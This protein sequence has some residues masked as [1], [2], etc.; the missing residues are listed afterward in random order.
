M[1]HR[2]TQWLASL[3]ADAMTNAEFRVLFHLCDCHNASGGCFP[4]QLFLQE[5]TNVSNGTLNNALNGL[6]ARGLIQRHRSRD[7]RTHRQRPT[8][9]TLGFDLSEPD[10]ADAPEGGDLDPSPE[11]GGGFDGSARKYE[12]KQSPA[13]GVGEGPSPVIGVGSRGAKSGVK[14]VPRLQSAGGGAVSKKTGG[15]TP[16]NGKSRLQ[17]TG[18]EPVIEPVNN[19]GGRGDGHSQPDAASMLAEKIGAGRYV[20]A[21]AVSPSM[22]RQMLSRNL[23]DASQLR[24]AGIAF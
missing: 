20:A 3:P 4:S 2:A 23:V 19:L 22:A 16:K 6:E 7:G 10:P 12:Q 21:S 13:G 11:T 17:P 15:P 18:E 5:R 14:P 8:R 1:S 24:A 9:Y